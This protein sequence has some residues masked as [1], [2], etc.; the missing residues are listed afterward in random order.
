VDPDPFIVPVDPTL[1]VHVGGVVCEQIAR[2]DGALWHSLGNP[3]FG[4][5]SAVASLLALPDGSALVGG[6]FPRLGG[7]APGRNLARWHP[8]NTWSSLGNGVDYRVVALAQGREGT[9]NV[10]G[11]FATAD[12]Q[13]AVMFARLSTTCPALE[14]S[15]GSA[16]TAPSGT[17]T[18]RA[19][20]LPWLAST[21][22][23]TSTGSSPTAL[24]VAVSGL[25]AA[26]VPLSTILSQAVV[27]CTL[28]VTPDHIEVAP[29][30]LGSA[31]SGFAVPSVPI[32]VGAVFRHQ[33]V[34][35]DFNLAGDL[36]AVTSSNAVALT[37][38]Q[39]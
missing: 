32:L 33:H 38:G 2:W 20:A 21:F 17:T 22:Q 12:G 19:T 28:L 11:W 6:L 16:C 3:T 7:F 30:P 24:V 31:V 27:G 10:G 1:V 4:S 5:G 9:V 35:L 15:Y 23:A 26:A 39:F 13:P 36:V 37:I 14:Q 25:S 34:A 29:A 8:N 18:L